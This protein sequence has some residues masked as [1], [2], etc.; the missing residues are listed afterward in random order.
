MHLLE[1]AG[2]AHAFPG[3]SILMVQ[4]GGKTRRALEHT[5]IAFTY[6]L[7][8]HACVTHP[9]C[10]RARAYGPLLLRTPPPSRPCDLR[11]CVGAVSGGMH[12]QMQCVGAWCVIRGNAFANA[13]RWC[14]VRYPAECGGQTCK[15]QGGKPP[16]YMDGRG[17]AK[18]GVRRYFHGGVG[19]IDIG[20]RADSRSNI[21]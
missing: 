3:A 9:A 7:H 14:V 21:I 15:S 20:V 13:V 19:V 6:I 5:C 1:P 18:N 4:V 12:S 10:R 2:R 11:A 16:M 17:A 8:T